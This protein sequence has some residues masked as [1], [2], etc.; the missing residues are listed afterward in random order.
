M[1]SRI[2]RKTL[3]FRDS[4]LL[5]GPAEFASSQMDGGVFRG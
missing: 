2:A 5:C 4:Q 1:T 3:K